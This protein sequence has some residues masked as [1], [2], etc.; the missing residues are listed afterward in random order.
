MS[1][2]SSS[3]SGTPSGP[4][5]G[6][7][8]RGDAAPP[9]RLGNADR[10]LLPVRGFVVALRDATGELVAGAPFIEVGRRRRW[11]S[12]AFTDYCAP[13]GES[14]ATG[15]LLRAL[16]E[17]RLAKGLRSIEI[18]DQLGGAETN[19]M[20]VGYRHQLALDAAPE[21]IHKRLNRSQVQQG[22]P[23]G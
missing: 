5:R 2:R 8:S 11:V 10:R 3:I 17:Q 12:L 6:V 23:A 15:R 18:R 14:E 20:R 9:P 21:E 7:H 1:L 13:L 19:K 4:V 22:D 16:E